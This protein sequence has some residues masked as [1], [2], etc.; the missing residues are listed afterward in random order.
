MADNGPE[1]TESAS[2]T[3][4]KP[5]ACVTF[6]YISATTWLQCEKVRA[7]DW[8]LCWIANLS[9]R[10]LGMRLQNCRQTVNLPMV[11]LLCFFFIPAEW[12]E[13][14]ANSTIFC[15]I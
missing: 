12:Q 8:E 14:H 1:C 10:W 3:S 13:L 7:C 2:Q 15:R 9:T 6:P 4:F 5:K 11:E